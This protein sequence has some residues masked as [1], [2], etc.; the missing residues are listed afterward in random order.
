MKLFA[1]LRQH[2]NLSSFLDVL[3]DTNVGFIA[4]ASQTYACAH[5]EPDKL[6]SAPRNLHQLLPVSAGKRNK[7]GTTKLGT[8]HSLFLS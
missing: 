6:L 7:D 1:C 2:I 4:K 5:T 8:Y 3:E